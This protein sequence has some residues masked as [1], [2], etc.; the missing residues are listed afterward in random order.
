MLIQLAPSYVFEHDG[1]I[2]VD[3]LRLL[4]AQLYYR[5]GAYAAAALDLDVLNPGAAPH[6]ADPL[7]LLVA[8]SVGVALERGDTADVHVLVGQARS[9]GGE[10]AGAILELDEHHLVPGR[11]GPGSAPQI[12]R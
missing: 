12:D 5:T 7:V 1:G 6:A 3:D 10:G 2:D 9:D 4:R 11:P 8:L